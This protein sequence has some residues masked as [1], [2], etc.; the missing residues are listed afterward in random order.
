MLTTVGRRGRRGLDAFV[1]TTAHQAGVT[2]CSY[3]TGGSGAA[4]TSTSTSTTNARGRGHGT[5]SEVTRAKELG[6]EEPR[7]G[8]RLISTWYAQEYNWTYEK[9]VSEFSPAEN[10]EHRLAV[11]KTCEPDLSG[12]K[13]LWRWMGGVEPT[14]KEA[15]TPTNAPTLWKWMCQSQ[16]ESYRRSIPVLGALVG[17]TSGSKG[18]FIGF[19]A[20]SSRK[21]TFLYNVRSN[22][23][24]DI[25]LTQRGEVMFDHLTANMLLMQASGKSKYSPLFLPMH[26]LRPNA[27]CTL[28]GLPRDWEGYRMHQ[29]LVKRMEEAGRV[30]DARP[31]TPITVVPIDELAFANFQKDTFLPPQLFVWVLPP[32]H[33]S[34]E[35]RRLVQRDIETA[36]RVA[37]ATDCRVVICG[38]EF[39]G[40]RGSNV[41]VGDQWDEFIGDMKHVAKAGATSEWDSRF[42]GQ[43]DNIQTQWLTEWSHNGMTL[44][45]VTRLLMLG[46][47]DR[48]REVTSKD[49]RAW[50]DEY[51]APYLGKQHDARWFLMNALFGG[52][53]FINRLRSRTRSFGDSI[54]DTT[55][56]THK[57]LQGK[58]TEEEI[59]REEEKLIA[60][61][62]T[63]EGKTKVFPPVTR[64]FDAL[65]EFRAA[66]KVADL[67]ADLK[68]LTT[69]AKEITSSSEDSDVV[70][71]EVLLRD[72]WAAK[73]RISEMNLSQVDPTVVA[74]N[75]QL[76]KVEQVTV[77][78]EMHRQAFLDTIKR[79]QELT[80]SPM[81][82]EGG[83]Q[84][85]EA[86][87]VEM[88]ELMRELSSRIQARLAGSALQ[89]SHDSLDE[90]SEEEITPELIEALNVD[91]G[92]V[93]EAAKSSQLGKVRVKALLAARDLLL[94]AED[95]D[96]VKLR[97][98]IKLAVDAGVDENIILSAETKLENLERQIQA[99]IRAHRIT[100][101]L[102]PAPTSGNE[103][104]SDRWVNAGQHIWY[105]EA[106]I[107][108]RGSLGTVVFKGYYDEGAGNR[109]VRRDAA[110]KRIPLP[111]GERGDNMKSL[112]ERE[113]AIHKHLNQRSNRVTHILGS[114]LN[115]DRGDGAI[116]TAMELC[117][118]SLAT[119]LR[120]AGAKGGAPAI[121]HSDRM[122][123]VRQLA[124]A[125]ED[126]HLAGVTHND[127]KADNCLRSIDGEFKLADLG[128][129]VR[130]KDANKATDGNTYSLTTFEGYG[131]NIGLQGR[132]PEVLLNAPLTP[133]VDVWSF[134]CLMYTIMTGLQSP[135]KQE[136]KVE[137][138]D[139]S[140][141]EQLDLNAS[142]ALD[143]G[144]E[145]QRIV[146]GKFSLQA[147]ETA[148]LPAHTTVAARELLHRM[149]DPDPKERPTASEVCEHP[150]MWDVEECM[151]AVREIYD[152]RIVNSLTEQEEADLMQNVWSGRSGQAER[153]AQAIRNW[154][155]IVVPSLLVRAEKYVQRTASM[156]QSW[157]EARAA[158][159]A[160]AA[161]AAA[162]SKDKRKNRRG[163]RAAQS[164]QQAPP[165]SAAQEPKDYSYGNRL[166]DLVRFARN[167]HE[168]PPLEAERAE[169][170][171]A[172]GTNVTSLLRPEDTAADPWTSSRKI[173]EAYFAHTFPDLPLFAHHLLKRDAEATSATAT[174]SSTTSDSA[175]AAS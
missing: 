69:R 94:A 60:F 86:Q 18:K 59:L 148:K 51:T 9:V 166:F 120:N 7:P 112:I 27:Y 127:I 161:A 95:V 111:P 66:I 157:E 74:F 108:G 42:A 35:N 26:L 84:A 96:P 130:I 31:N 25:E 79:I 14:P 147:I 174:T 100:D 78:G 163:G 173:V 29:L 77:L 1:R 6:L 119:W 131:V 2:S 37:K 104:D 43:L 159:A 11:Q 154:K 8:S 12:P 89:V 133:K 3:S 117:G 136:R 170:L 140:S 134:G 68:E 164:P 28:A 175:T 144:F 153:A 116:Y 61:Y 20:G 47:S 121:P 150:V 19:G 145:N 124:N 57:F 106:E 99:F 138:R 67:R 141:Q 139:K 98:K 53:R 125:V 167:M 45:D 13:W 50:F 82:V 115:V 171:R 87:S 39:A 63:P 151:E 73:G 10:T 123:A 83:P 152:R 110:I 162:K 137:N 75:L 126:V 93:D 54:V 46:G 118:E 146:K 49:A 149:L 81:P 80:S 168:H 92:D 22:K 107:L 132:P 101:S 169:M 15:L 109:V 105:N 97:E 21:S 128:L 71:A 76:S 122:D 5:S 55:Q 56:H 143:V 165:P 114:K 158:K 58:M 172:L 64:I 24:M 17:Q 72:M 70:K 113:I 23:T 41:S 129:G 65:R 91:A 38:L 34:A 102:L 88:E 33:N 142:T 155:S 52:L 4:S 48:R 90:M 36:L 30:V 85:L 160:A 156:Q 62:D 16:V 103:S 44:P 40:H 32:I 135:Y